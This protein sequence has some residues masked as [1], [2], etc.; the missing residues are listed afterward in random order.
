[1]A[2]F[3]DL[4]NWNCF[5]TYSGI[6]ARK[7]PFKYIL[8]CK[9]QNNLQAS[10]QNNVLPSNQMLWGRCTGTLWQKTLGKNSYKNSAEM[11]VITLYPREYFD[12]WCYQPSS[13]TFEICRFL[14]IL[15]TNYCFI[16]DMYILCSYFI[17]STFKT[18][19]LPEVQLL[20]H[21]K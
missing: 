9:P 15:S 16:L 20:N 7:Y 6:S 5:S 21:I 19:K 14:Y 2:I 12:S 13:S 1:M 10:Q 17:V 8:T 11:H 18:C 3:K 4:I